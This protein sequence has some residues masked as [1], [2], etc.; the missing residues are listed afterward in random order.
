MFIKEVTCNVTFYE[1]LVLGVE[2][3]PNQSQ[4]VYLQGSDSAIRTRGAAC[5]KSRGLARREGKTSFRPL[6]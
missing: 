2:P 3:K 4:R 5:T 1:V 6:N